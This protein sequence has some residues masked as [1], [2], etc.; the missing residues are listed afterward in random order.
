M[1]IETTYLKVMNTQ[2]NKIPPDSATLPSQKSES[3][4]KTRSPSLLRYYCLTLNKSVQQED[5]YMVAVVRQHGVKKWGLISDL[6]N[7]K[8][9]VDFRTAKL[10]RERYNIP[11]I[12]YAVRWHNHLDPSI[13]KKAWTDQEEMQFM[14]AHTVL[15]NRWAEI[16]KV[17]K[18]RYEL[19]FNI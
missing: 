7:H 1:R 3:N 10:C 2:A 19:V 4:G 12:N 17:L 13:N 15:G 5:D 6:M 11:T 8:F 18:G 16:S 14:A 9:G